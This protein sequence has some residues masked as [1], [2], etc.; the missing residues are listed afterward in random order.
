MYPQAWWNNAWFTPPV[1]EPGS[2][3]AVR[4]GWEILN[5]LARYFDPVQSHLL[6]G[7]DFKHFFFIPNLGK[8]S[9][10]TN[11]FQMGWNHQLD[12]NSQILPGYCLVSFDVILGQPRKRIRDDFLK[13]CSWHLGGLC[14]K[15]SNSLQCL[16]CFYLHCLLC[17]NWC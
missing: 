3:P 10:L 12:Y 8:W 11:N 7:G 13:E 15:G 5:E 17:V 4:R 9:N 2:G 14:K 16:F 6:L 1:A